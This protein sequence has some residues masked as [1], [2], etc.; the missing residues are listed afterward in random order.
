MQGVTVRR[1]AK[2]LVK[3]ESEQSGSSPSP[4]VQ[5]S[6]FQ[7]G[8][9]VVFVRSLNRICDIFAIKGRNNQIEA[10]SAYVSRNIP[11]FRLDMP[12]SPINERHPRNL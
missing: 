9:V 3:L 5:T 12:E 8:P 6:Y 10:S 2:K 7:V 11:N 4:S 1:Y